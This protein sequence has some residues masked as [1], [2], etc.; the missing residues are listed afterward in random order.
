MMA[1]TCTDRENKL[2]K[3]IPNAYEKDILIADKYLKNL[4]FF[5]NQWRNNHKIKCFNSQK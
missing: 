4:K 3:N 1:T 5:I 2:R